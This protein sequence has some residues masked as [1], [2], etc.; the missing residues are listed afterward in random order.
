MS[1][2][3][4]EVREA[5][6][7]HPFFAGLDPA[8]VREAAVGAEP[9]TFGPGTL[10]AREGTPAETFVLVVAGKIAL[11]VGAPDRPT[12]TVQ[13]IGPGEVL[14]WSWLLPP[15]RWRFDARAVKETHVLALRGDRLRPALAAHPAWGFEFLRRFVP[16][17]AE[18][19]ENTRVQLVDLH[20]R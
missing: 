7:R 8:F 5:I 11:E 20:A 14:G 18:R 6:G 10:V 1:E 9:R 17:L 4:E 3:S 15:H 19:L 2:I 16:V 12:L 13:T